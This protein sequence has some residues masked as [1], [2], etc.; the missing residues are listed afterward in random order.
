MTGTLGILSRAVSTTSIVTS[1]ASLDTTLTISAPVKLARR[2]RL[3]LLANWT[4]AV[5]SDIWA[6]EV[7]RDGTV[8]TRIG[9]TPRYNNGFG[10][11]SSEMPFVP[12]A[13][14]TPSFV[15][16]LTRISGSGA[17]TLA[18]A[19]STPTQF[20]LRDAGE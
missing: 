11:I 19:A 16:R 7:L 20:D 15:L 6:F 9:V 5:I 12:A 10:V 3:R 18:G 2:Y 14:S 13:D 1:S 8:V 17:L 4:L